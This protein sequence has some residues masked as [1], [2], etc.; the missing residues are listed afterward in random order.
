[1]HDWLLDLADLEVITVPVQV[2][3]LGELVDSS[4]LIAA[5]ESVDLAAW[6][7]FVAGEVVISNELLTRLIYVPG[8][9]KLL[10]SQ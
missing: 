4:D 8:V 7:D 3:V 5:A 10:S 6:V 9:W 1:V 2:K